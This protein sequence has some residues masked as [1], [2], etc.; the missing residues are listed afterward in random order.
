MF[1]WVGAALLINF[2]VS[3]VLD[4]YDTE[5]DGARPS[6]GL[7]FCGV[8]GLIFIVRVCSGWT[9]FRAGD[10]AN[11]I[12]KV[13]TRN[14]TQDMQPSDPRHMRIVPYELACWMA[15]KQLGEAPGT[16][17]SQFCIAKDHLTLQKVKGELWYVA[18]LDY[19]GF[20]VW[21]SVDCAPGYVMV[22]AE[23]QNHPVQLVT[24]CKF[25]YTPGAFFRYNLE[26]HIWQNGYFFKGL[27]D[28]S[29][30]IDDEGKPWWVVTVFEPTVSFWGCKI[31][32]VVIVDPENGEMTFHAKDKVPAWVDR[33]IPQEFAADYIHN[34]GMLSGGWLNSWWSCKDLRMPSPFR[35]QKDAVWIIY[36]TDGE[37]YWFT[38]ITSANAKDQALVGMMCIHSRTGEARFYRASGMNE[39]AVATAVENAVKYKLLSAAT[40]IPQNIYGTMTWVLPL[41]GQSHTFQGVALVKADTLQ[42]AIGADQHEALTEYQKIINQSGQQIAPSTDHQRE[43]FSGKVLR[44]EKD[45]RKGESAYYLYMEGKGFI[46]IGASELS[47]TLPITR[48]GDEV[49]VRYIDTKESKVPMLSFENLSVKVRKSELEQSLQK[50]VTSRQEEQAE[51]EKVRD[52][53]RSVENMST[54]E[55]R[56]A[57]KKNR[58]ER[59]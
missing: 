32:G 19:D 52:V 14:W 11:L 16:L 28:Y 30:E 27:I 37:P 38:G 50:Q 42:A 36:G 47:P 10:Y 41:L 3:T 9:A 57:L 34:W 48:E 40:P 20:P 2:V 7:L 4:M 31:T 33:A 49:K 6:W 8:M 51:K 25:L 43:E 22:H 59:K 35:G 29:F 24:G 17:G 56:A 18:P 21:T 13:E 5:R 45:V 39:D 55:L 54:E 1:G 26:R 12:G 23:D 46:F 58:T 15:D 53:D 44:I